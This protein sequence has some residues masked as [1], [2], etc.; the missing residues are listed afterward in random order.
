MEQREEKK[1]QKEEEDK[2]AQ[3]E[4]EKKARAQPKLMSFF[5]KPSTPKK[6]ASTIVPLNSSPLKADATGSHQPPQKTEYEKLFRPFYMRENTRMA[7]DSCRMDQETK[8]TKSRILD[9]CIAGKRSANVSFDPM[10]LFALPGISRPR[11]RGRLHPPVRHIM[12]AVYKNMELSA[13]NGAPTAGVAES[14]RKKLIGVPCKIIAFSRDVRPPYYGTVTSLPFAAGC[15]KMRKVAR[16]S[17]AR[18]L[19]LDYDYDSEA[20]WQED[21]GEDL[22]G[23]DGD[24]ELDDED[25]MDGFLDDSEDLGLS[26]RT[27]GNTMEPETTG[28]CF[29]NEDRK[30]CSQAAYENKMELILGRWQLSRS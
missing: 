13:A 16:N 7:P 25:D 17:T 21:E 19:E 30:C 20:E 8:E 12:E 6:A 1:K 29:E 10:S 22:D 18:R 24:E 2:R 5:G 11:P 4:L 9:E 28:I 26:R 15:D 14:A 23:D 27:F 3:E